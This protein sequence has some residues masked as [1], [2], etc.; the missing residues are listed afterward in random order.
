MSAL[1][2]PVPHVADMASY[3]LADIP[4]DEIVSLAQNESAF[5]VSMRAVE[6]GMAALTTT[7]LYPDPDWHDLRAAIGQVYRVDPQMILCGAGSMELIG[8]LIQAYAGPGDEVLG[9]AYGYLFAQTAAAQARATYVTAPETDFCLDVDHL[10]QAVTHRT[11]IVF[12]CNPGNPTGTR[13]PNAEIVRLRDRLPASILLILDQAYGE[14][15]DQDQ[16]EVF[17]LPQRGNTVVLRTLSKAYG[18]ASARVGWGIFPPDV[19]QETRKLL[20]PNNVSGIS[21]AMAAAAIR[22]QVHMHSVVEMT[23]RIRMRFAETLRSN[24]FQ[25]PVS[26]TNFVLIAFSDLDEAREADNDLRKAGYLLR[27]IA[28]YGL[29]HCLRATVGS[30]ETMNAVAQ[31]LCRF[32]E[33]HHAA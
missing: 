5:P 1:V 17:D 6:A 21:Q 11:R 31:C 28:G 25:V 8:C 15:D 27:N 14:F 26:H 24:G 10:L 19:A 2:P 23:S 9:S 4:G 16:T 7:S 18:M 22:D 13:I 32:R 29:P 33:A 3:A 30:V 20:N 12:I